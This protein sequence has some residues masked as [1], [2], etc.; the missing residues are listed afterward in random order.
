M[1]MP[2]VFVIGGVSFD[3]LLY[4]DTFPEP[5]PQTLGARRSHETIGSTGAGKALNLCR[6]GFRVTLHGLLGDDDGGRRVR[7]RL[8]GEPLEFLHDPDPLGTPRHVNLMDAA[9]R[10]IS[11]FAVAGSF[12]PELDLGRLTV[13]LA[14]CDYLVLNIIN[15]ARRLIPH[16]RSAG[17]AVW[18]DIHDYDG[19]NPYHRDF[20]EAADYLFL[21]SEALPD[22]RGFMEARVRQGTRLVVC[23]HGSH[24][25][26]RTGAVAGDARRDR[27]WARGQQRCRG[28]L[29]RGLSVRPRPG[30]RH[31]PVSE[32]GG[33]HR[34]PVRRLP[35]VVPS[36]PQPRHRGSR[37]P[38]ADRRAPA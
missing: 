32:T 37:L 6:L 15:Y 29:F 23:T 31:G 16:A 27:L 33:D 18:C 11:I 24:G 20:I 30:L 7:E 19:Y 28:C 1:P 34:G 22:W 25:A 10:R 14:D 26:D 21:S 35:G 4:L 36:R 8:A 17:K 13:R 38:P 3:H 2:S 9:G 12:E 5:A